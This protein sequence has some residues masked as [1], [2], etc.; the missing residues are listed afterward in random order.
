M[1]YNFSSVSFAFFREMKRYAIRK[2][3]STKC[4]TT[5]NWNSSSGCQVIIGIHLFFAYFIQLPKAFLCRRLWPFNWIS[6]GIVL[7]R[8]FAT[9]HAYVVMPGKNDVPIF[10]AILFLKKTSFNQFME[11]T[12]MKF[13]NPF[14]TGKM[15]PFAEIKLQQW[16]FCF[17]SKLFLMLTRWMTFPKVWNCSWV[18]CNIFFS[19]K[20]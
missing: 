20:K 19:R 17:I 5:I 10:R 1:L 8:S 7:L 12:F 2:R 11:S 13:V 4:K 9:F 16:H 6:V 18:Q 15:K 3:E 14:S